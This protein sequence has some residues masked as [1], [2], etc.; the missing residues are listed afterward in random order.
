MSAP[1]R[2]ARRAG[3]DILINGATAE[4]SSLLQDDWGARAED[5]VPLRYAVRQIEALTPIAARA[6]LQLRAGAG[7]LSVPSPRYPLLTPHSFHRSSLLPPRPDT[8]P[9][10]VPT[11]MR[12]HVAAVRGWLRILAHSGRLQP[13]PE[14]KNHGSMTDP[15]GSAAAGYPS[16]IP[17][18]RVG[19]Q[20]V[21]VNDRRIDVGGRPVPAG[22]S[23][24]E[25]GD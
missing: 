23:R 25:V 1:P 20:R 11:G 6:P 9:A 22:H 19:R 15:Y 12:P 18:L 21:R 17:R 3:I 13:P 24:V 16:I 4:S 14:P 2:D 7:S 5:W 10:A 8:F